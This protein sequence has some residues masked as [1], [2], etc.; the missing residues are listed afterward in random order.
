MM[1]VRTFVCAVLS[2]VTVTNWRF[3]QQR[4]TPWKFNPPPD[5]SGRIKLNG[6]QWISWSGKASFQDPVMFDLGLPGFELEKLLFTS[7]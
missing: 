5:Q 1:K 4:K 7:K 2:F 6:Q 3:H